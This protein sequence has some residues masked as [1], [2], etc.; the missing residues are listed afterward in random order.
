MEMSPLTNNCKRQMPSTRDHW[1]R[2]KGRKR[3]TLPRS[4]V[5]AIR[6]CYGKMDATTVSLKFN[7]SEYVIERIWKRETY[8]YILQIGKKWS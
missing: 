5:I 1:K 8:R 6:D 4:V 2:A 7:V 3:D